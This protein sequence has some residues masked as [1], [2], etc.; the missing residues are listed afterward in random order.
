M[1]TRYRIQGPRMSMRD[2]TAKTSIPAKLADAPEDDI[3]RLTREVVRART[4]AVRTPHSS[5]HHQPALLG[6]TGE[7]SMSYTETE[8]KE[9][10]AEA[11]ALVQ[12]QAAIDVIRARQAERQRGADLK[13]LEDNRAEL[14]ERRNYYED[15]LPVFRQQTEDYENKRTNIK[16]AYEAVARSNGLRPP[17]AL[18]YRT[19]SRPWRGRSITTRKRSGWRKLQAEFAALPNPDTLQRELMDVHGHIN[20][21]EYSVGNFLRKLE[22]GSGKSWLE[23]GSG[24]LGR[25]SV[26]A[27]TPSAAGRRGRDGRPDSVRWKA[28]ATSGRGATVGTPAG[29]DETSVFEAFTVYLR[30]GIDRSCR[31]VA[32][33]VIQKRRVDAAMVGAV[34]LAGPGGDVRPPACPGCQ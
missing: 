6:Q 23:G 1:G 13:Q 5:E 8:Q 28:A 32:F 11:A 4:L 15:R 22:G 2:T 20:R 12:H 29:G 34:E 16:A 7:P 21:L 26:L 18:C 31:S 19:T 24:R 10:A 9:L 25:G 33:G 3:N 30:Q 27:S 14:S 17:I